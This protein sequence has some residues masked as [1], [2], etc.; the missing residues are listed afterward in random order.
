[1]DIGVSGRNFVIVGGTQRI[2]YGAAR[3]L[4]AEG[5][6]VALLARDSD[7]TRD[8]AEGLAEEFGIKAIGIAVDGTES[9]GHFFSL[10]VQGAKGDDLALH[11]DE[12][13]GV[14]RL[15]KH[16]QDIRQG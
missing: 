3:V 15:K 11:G 12:G 8:K 9:S 16:G 6:N 1:M 13:S 10:F 5:A 14:E 4:A 7:R 2:G